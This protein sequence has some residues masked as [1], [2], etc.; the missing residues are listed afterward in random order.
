M[1]APFLTESEGPVLLSFAQSI[2]ANATADIATPPT[3]VVAPS[4]IHSSPQ[5]PPPR[6]DLA[7]QGSLSQSCH[8]LQQQQQQ[9]GSPG[10]PI[11]YGPICLG[12][13]YL[14]PPGP[15]C[16]YYHFISCHSQQQQVSQLQPWFH[17][18]A[19]P[20]PSQTATSFA[21][22]GSFP[23]TD[24]LQEGGLLGNIAFD[25]D[26]LSLSSSDASVPQGFV[27]P[28]SPESFTLPSQQDM[29]QEMKLEMQQQ[30]EYQPQAAQRKKLPDIPARA[31]TPDDAS[32]ES[33]MTTEEDG[34]SASDVSENDFNPYLKTSQ[35]KKNNARK[36]EERSL[37][38]LSAILESPIEPQAAERP[39]PDAWGIDNDRKARDRFLV[40]CRSRGMTYREIK[41]AGKMHEAE[42]TLRGRHRVLTKCK[43]QRIR[44]PQWTK[45]DASRPRPPRHSFV[46]VAILTC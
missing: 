45:K 31:Q 9:P 20:L 4:S 6:P 39:M 13:G 24:G 16:S 11:N 26:N 34:S 3:S 5:E 43:A 17:N 25:S 10:H 40:A 42:S 41:K 30:D 12:E 46:D 37:S 19:L 1:N 36:R 2:N 22:V 21:D 35:R 7:S 33:C 44:K 23:K 32:E 38:P 8:L 27:I 28:D 14:L 18:A 15:D 29:K